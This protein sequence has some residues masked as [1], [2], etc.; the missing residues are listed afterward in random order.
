M[1]PLVAVLA[2]AGTSL[3]LGETIAVISHVEDRGT[4]AAAPEFPS[5]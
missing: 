3:V 1:K 5:A 2:L 4:K